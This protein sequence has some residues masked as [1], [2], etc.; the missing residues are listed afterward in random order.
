M[1]QTDAR[2]TSLANARGKDGR[3]LQI[4]GSLAEAIRL[5]EEEGLPLAEAATSVGYSRDALYAAFA[6]PHVKA[7][8][9]GVKRAWLQ[10]RTTKAWHNIANLADGAKSEDVKMKANKV[11]LEAAGELGATDR[12]DARPTT[13]IQIV[14]QA[15]STVA[16]PTSGLIEAPD[17][18]DDDGIIEAEYTSDG[19]D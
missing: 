1:A 11:F 15:G 4:R 10:A 5:I 3:K 6:K 18:A 2:A 19:I 13:L 9:A 16:V 17:Y 8:R 7:Y 12:G 14:A